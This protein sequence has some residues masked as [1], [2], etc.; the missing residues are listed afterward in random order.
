PRRPSELVHAA[1]T[2][3]GIAGIILTFGQAVD[4][5]VLIYERMREE[6]KRG[7]DMRTAVRLGFSKAF[8]SIVDGNVANLIICAVLYR[9]GTQEIR[10][11]AITLSI[12]VLATLFAALVVSRLIFTI[13][14]DHVGWSRTSML[15]MA[16][17]AV[18]RALEWKVNWLRLRWFFVTASILLTGL[19]IIAAVV[20]GPQMLDTEFR[21]G[22][23]IE[24][25]FKDDP[26]SDPQRPRPLMLTRQDVLNRV[27]AI[28]E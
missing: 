28:A 8:A 11:F 5:N 13:L 15:P 4:S 1:F 21:G 9:F 26:Q 25:Q 3:P 18:Q 14:V 24:L 19:G 17:P 16:V 7:A 22:T 2:L 20:R 27:E 23:Q 10:G 6:F 12:G